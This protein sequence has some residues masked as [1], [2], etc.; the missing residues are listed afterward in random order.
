MCRSRMTSSR[1]KTSVPPDDD[2]NCNDALSADF[3]FDEWVESQSHY[4]NMIKEGYTHVGVGV[5]VG[6]RNG[7]THGYA[8]TLFAKMPE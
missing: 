1:V 3:W 7:Y 5:Y 6:E 4:E 8:C 2:P